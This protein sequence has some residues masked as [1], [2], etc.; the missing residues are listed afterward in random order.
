[1]PAQI[2]GALG[3]LQAFIK[4]FSIAQRTLGLIGIAGVV[5][6]AIA[7]SS[8]LTKPTMSP[9]F[10]DVS[11]ADASAIVDQLTGEGVPYEL[12]DGGRTILV[13]QDQ[14]YAMRL[15][16][17]AAG[18]PAATDGAGYSL[19]DN[20][21]M[22]ASEFQ[23]TT[24]YRRA[25]EGELAKTIGAMNGV[26]AATVKL[27]MPEQTVFVSDTADP[28]ASVFLQTSRGTTLQAEQVTAIVHLVSAGVQGMKPTDV[29]VVDAEGHVLSAVGGLPGGGMGD[30]QTSDYQTRV[31]AS[32][33]AMLDRVVGAGKA[34]VTVNAE[35][36]LD[37]TD[38]TSETFTATPGVPALSSATTTE[39]YSGTGGT[40]AGVLGPDNIAV[41]G[42]ADGTGT[43]TKG[44]ENL[45][46]AVDKVTEH[47]TTTPGSVRRQSVSVV[48][49]QDAGAAL[50]MTDLTTMV[51]VAAGIDTTRGDSVAVSRMA[52]DTTTAEAA[53]AAL[54][55]A[56][57]E[58]KAVAQMDLIKQGAI[59]GA[60]LLLLLI[61][62]VIAKRKSGKARR[63]ALDLGE[64]QM[65]NETPMLPFG[66]LETLALIP[67]APQ[68]DEA[69]VKRAEIG[70]LAE[71][72]PAEVADL[73]RGWLQ[74]GNK[75]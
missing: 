15:K 23:Q 65:V 17:A 8:Y 18:L 24:T 42:G 61:S 56:D 34:V 66:G 73:L 32:V 3:R 59:A 43:Y 52:F 39:T 62:F 11:T 46:P 6:G 14:L 54:G 41:P 64:L 37:N 68:I 30:Q 10:A 72:Q 31:A 2:T 33:Q 13:P 27:A 40:A 49:D 44:S 35:L 25:M 48:V 70:N 28:T 16:A 55:A 57:A 51:T 38:L 7:L 19:L 45:N 60:I 21:G 9:L 69:A 5:L 75:R 63:E 53:Q 4:Q 74:T 47:T 36:N 22:T 58:A 67:A 50:N 12:T 71:D 1:M 26:E 20:M 29:S